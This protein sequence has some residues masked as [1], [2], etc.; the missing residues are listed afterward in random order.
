MKYLVDHDLHIHSKLSSCSNDPLQTTEAI[1]QYAVDNGLSSICVTDHF[2]DSTVDGASGWYAPQNLAHIQENLPLPMHEG[3][4][5]FFGC[6]TELTA[7]LSLGISPEA[8]RAL[9]FVI[10]PLNHFHMQGYTLHPNASAQERADAFLRR[11][12]F[13][14]SYDLPFRK[15]GIAHPA[16]S[17]MAAEGRTQDVIERMDKPHLSDLFA[18]MAQVE[19][20]RAHV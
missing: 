8:A 13:V 9:D 17:L 3:V 2:W 6:E 1:L 10:I 19:I 20:G 5:F 18:R 16:C 11:L 7:N 12:D 15:I 14:L 4:R